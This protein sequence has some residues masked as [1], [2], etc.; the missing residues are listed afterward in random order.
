MY[1][2]YVQPN[3]WPLFSTD[4]LWFVFASPN[5]H[6][7]A[8]HNWIDRMSRNF[9]HGTTPNRE[10]IHISCSKWNKFS[11]IWNNEVSEKKKFAKWSKCPTS[12]QLPSPTQPSPCALMR[13][14][15]RLFLESPIICNV[16]YL[17]CHFIL[18]KFFDVHYK[19][20]LHF[21]RTVCCEEIAFVTV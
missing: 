15:V 20:C 2:S 7:Y 1:V 21:A 18:L 4:I 5:F 14:F 13:E 10:N 8:I 6:I 19:Y 9:R 17:A 11:T 12:A 16:K 3:G